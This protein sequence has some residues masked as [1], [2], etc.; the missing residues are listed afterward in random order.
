MT[1]YTLEE[2]V[3]S[4]QQDAAK[5]DY[6]QLENDRMLEVNL[7]GEVWTKTG[8]MVAYVGQ[9][10]F[11]REKIL[12]RGIG[13]LLKKTVTGEGARLTRAIGQGRL[14][15]ADE[16]KTIQ[17]LKLENQSI[18][19]NGNDLLAFEPTL[20]WDI[21][22]MRKMAALMSG[23]LFNVLVQGTGLVAITSHFEPLALMVR[24][25]QPV[26]TD[27]NATICW[28]GNLQPEFK[29]DVSLKTFFGRGSGESIQMEFNGDGFVVI[30][31]YE[32]VVFQNTGASG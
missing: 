9:I 23:G 1:N 13:N 24:P 8:S 20:S 27:P 32:E 15:L 31:P 29:T 21:K 14:Y 18:Y 5:T 22:M 30:Q 3:T 4:N 17:I 6:F 12:E 19:V 26:R 28:S 25:G 16:G 10:K 11:E 2:F 7:N